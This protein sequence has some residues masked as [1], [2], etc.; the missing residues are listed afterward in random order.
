M[1]AETASRRALLRILEGQ[2]RAEAAL[3]VSQ[4]TLQLTLDAAQ[5]GYWDLDLI[6]HA[7]TR[8]LRHDLI[9]G[10]T[11]LLE[12]WRYETFLL[13][14]HPEDRE[15]VDL[16]FQS[17]VAAKSE[18]DFE[19]RIFRVDGLQRWIWGHGK[20]FSNSTGDAVKMLGMVLD[21]TARK[22]LEEALVDREKEFRSLAE[23]MPQI[24]WATRADGWNIYFNQQ[25]VDYTGLSLEESHGQGWNK[26]FH[27]DDL[28]R[29]WDAWQ[30]AVHNRGSYAMECRLRRVDGIYRWWLIRGVPALD[31]G[32]NIVKWF[33][34]C[35]DIEDI[36]LN[37]AKLREKNIELERFTYMI[38][39]D[40]K[41]P[42]VTIGTFLNYLEQDLAK[43]DVDLVAKDM[44]YIAKAAEKM[45]RMLTELFEF[46]RVGRVRQ[47]LVFAQWRDV[48]DEALGMVAG[49]IASRN[50]HVDIDDARVLLHGE[51]ERL[52]QIWQNLL[53]NAAKF[54]GDQADLRVHIGVEGQGTATI[55]FVCDN[56][57]GIDPR[58]HEKIFLLFERLD[59][60]APGTGL[61]LALV[62][63][64]VEFYG[65]TIKVESR[66]LGFGA[67]FRFTLPKA[68]ENAEAKGDD[69]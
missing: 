16:L 2:Q 44:H 61:G 33:G 28:K 41:S 67:C 62:K 66:G 58:Y 36:K 57:I 29:A 50:V 42:L 64:V 47:K 19:C 14:V 27:P 34:T 46:T 23:S 11:E 51:R 38:S 48:V 25:W 10:Y 52:V 26:P 65:G 3:R 63:R 68:F 8:S 35:T 31:E 49:V 15:R 56:G 54:G 18:W 69:T 39:H 4:E 45:G 43:S 24:V 17:G 22:Q 1:A 32:G 12:N 21:I 5:I 53:D 55:F 9:F 40:L 30:N 60:S 6:T 59:T 20:I 13:H 37:E 7:A